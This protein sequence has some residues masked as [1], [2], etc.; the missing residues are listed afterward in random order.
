MAVACGPASVVWES[1]L[2]CTTCSMEGKVLPLERTWCSVAQGPTCSRASNPAADNTQPHLRV[3]RKLSRITTNLVPIILRETEHR[4][5]V[6]RATGLAKC[7]EWLSNGSTSLS[8]QSF[9]REQAQHATHTTPSSNLL[10]PTPALSFLCC[11]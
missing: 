11:E 1:A 9:L 5:L 7:N 2:Q 6:P 8:S 3:L 10:I 4:Q